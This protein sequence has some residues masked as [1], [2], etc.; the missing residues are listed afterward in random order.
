M[1]NR[2]RG[3]GQGSIRKRPDGL[4][5]ARI[6]YGPR[7]ARRQLSGYGRTEDDA[8]DAL[9]VKLE[10]ERRRARLAEI[11]DWTVGEYLA[12]WV[13]E[14]LAEQVADGQ[15]AETT[16]ISY[17]RHVRMRITPHL[18]PLP[19]PELGP[20][21][22][23][24]WLADLRRDGAHPRQRQYARAVLSAALSTAVR[25]EYVD[26]NVVTLV[27][28]PTVRYERRPE[29]PVD[30]A[31]RLLA[32]AQQ[33]R[34]AAL[35]TLMLHIPLRPGEPCGAVWADFDLGRGLYRVR[36]NLVRVG[37][38]WQLH[39]LK[40]HRERTVPLPDVVV[41]ALHAHRERADLEASFA[42]WTDPTVIDVNGQ[43]ITVDLVFRSPDGTPLW[44][45]RIGKE[46]ETVC[47]V[48]KVPRLTPHGLR[49]AATSL[50]QSTGVHPA[51][52]QQLGG[53]SQGAMVDHYT[54]GLADAMR[55]AVNELEQRLQER[56][57]SG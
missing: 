47:K 26:R 12:W 45:N 13:D 7:G 54:G 53:W 23:R 42:G 2:K 29:V 8:W 27:Q 46:L 5:E 51:V 48:A 41:T 56:G 40:G 36:R 11:A 28:A 20:A 9:E 10:H 21:H 1:A 16:R 24:R 17:A 50:L 33:S 18:G 4:Y 35:F 32:A 31:R 57:A 25:Y 38:R 55:A 52:V 6:S 49:H 14:E 15:L 30:D 43:E 37:G 19:L 39:D 3:A 44:W 34:L 22:V